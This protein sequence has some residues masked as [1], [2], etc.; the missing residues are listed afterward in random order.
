MTP[1]SSDIVEPN[2]PHISDLLVSHYDCSRQYNIR[3]FSLTRVKPCAQAPSARESTGVFANVFVHAKANRPKASTS[4]AYVKRENFVGAQS[5]YKCR[6]H[7]HTDFH[8]STMDR[9]RTLDPTECKHAIRIPY[10]TDNPQLNAFEYSDF[11]NSLPL[12][13]IRKQC[14]LETNQPPFRISKL[15][16]L[17]YG[18]FA[19]TANTQLVLKATLEEKAVCWERYEKKI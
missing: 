8:K 13:D 5:D 14:L 16:T 15:N 4:E 11:N 1:P 9:P 6:R 12:F 3:H 7:D 17:H 10:G 19:W 2:D 18:A